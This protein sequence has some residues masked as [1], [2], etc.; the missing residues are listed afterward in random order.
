MRS[1]CPC[2]ISALLC[3]RSFRHLLDRSAEISLAELLAS[4]ATRYD[5]S[6]FIRALLVKTVPFA[7][8]VTDSGES[9]LG[10]TAR[11]LL[12]MIIQNVPLS[13]QTATIFVR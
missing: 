6:A 5:V 9:A 1:T 11:Q 13:K 8:D 10:G 7:V 4:L 2:H 12:V 3:D